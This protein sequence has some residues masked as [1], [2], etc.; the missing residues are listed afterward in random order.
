MI[1]YNIRIIPF[2][3]DKTCGIGEPA[4]Y[5]LEIFSQRVCVAKLGKDKCPNEIS[6]YSACEVNG[7]VNIP[8]GVL[9]LSH[10]VFGFRAPSVGVRV[11]SADNDRLTDEI[12]IEEGP[13]TY[14]HEFVC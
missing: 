10:F 5:M 14:S 12:F 7:P 6:P 11:A 3:H 8:R 2:T 4:Q 13:R 9:M 1:R